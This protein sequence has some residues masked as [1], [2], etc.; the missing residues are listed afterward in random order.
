MVDITDKD[1]IVVNRE[2]VYSDHSDYDIVQ[3][4]LD[5]IYNGLFG[6]YYTID[7]VSQDALRGYYVEYYRAEMFNG[8]FAQFVRN[9]H[10]LSAGSQFRRQNPSEE[11]DAAQV[12][13]VREGLVAIGATVHI[14]LFDEGVALV[15]SLGEVRL[16]RFFA[17]SFQ[18]YAQSPERAVLATIDRRF[19]EL[20]K[21]QSLRM[22][23]RAWLRTHPK[24]VEAT[25]EQIE[26]EIQRRAGLIPDRADRIAAA[27]ANIPLRD[28]AEHIEAEIQRRRTALQRPMR[29]PPD[30]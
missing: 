20:N 7:E 29:M 4:N 15:E 8:G 26:A 22:L 9:S 21:Q 2:S 1:A 19:V 5:F 3:A 13:L 6:Q 27:E 28:M 10:R 17:A 30:K 14:K 23:N 12:R 16:N 24:L 11:P 18:N 25:S